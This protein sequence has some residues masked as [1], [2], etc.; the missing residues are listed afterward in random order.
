MSGEAS[1]DF[2][3]RSTVDLG[4]RGLDN[5][6]HHPDT[7]VLCLAYAFDGGDVHIWRS[8]VGPHGAVE[9]P[10]PVALLEH[11]ASG[12]MIRGWN[13]GFEWAIWN[14]IMARRYGWPPL[15]ITQCVD[16][17]AEAYAMGFPGSLGKAAA[18]LQLEEQKDDAGH[19]LMLRLSKPRAPRK[20]EIASLTYWEDDPAK[21]DRLYEYCKQDVRTEMAVAQ[22]LMRLAPEERKLWLLDHAINQTGTRIDLAAAHAAKAV[23][24]IEQ[25]RLDDEMR[26]VTGGAVG[27]CGS[28]QKLAQWL[29][30]QGVAAKGVAKDDVATLLDSADL[31]EH[32][33]AALRLRKEAAKS[34]TAKLDA[35]IASAS[36]DGRVRGV[37]QYHG[38]STG[39]WTGRT[40]QTQNIPRGEILKKGQVDDVLRLLVDLEGRPE[41]AADAL[42]VLYGPPLQVVSDCLRGLICATPGNR[43]IVA[44]YSAIEA[45]VLAWLAG[46]ESVL[47]V[48]RTHG[49]LYETTASSLFGVAL[50]GVT[51]EQRQIGKVCD[52][53]LGYGGSVGAFQSMARIYGLHLPDAR[54][55]EIVGTWRAG[56]AAI[57]AYWAALEHAATS[58]VAKGGKWRAGAAGCEV[59]FVHGAGHL[60]CKLPS[61]RVLCYP[62]ARIGAASWS[63]I[64]GADGETFSA[65]VSAVDADAMREGAARMAQNAGGRVV[66]YGSPR[67]AVVYR[68]VESQTKQWV[69]SGTYGGHLS[70]NITQAVA[71]DLLSEAMLRVEAAGYAI[72]MH[73]HDEIVAEVPDSFG[74]VEEFERIMAELPSWAQGLP[75]SAKGYAAQRFRK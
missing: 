24:A 43:L 1:V 20:N 4:P 6:A 50:D 22:R 18:A 7:D 46:E 36:L 19:R 16:T 64:E 58:A 2:E 51:P 56:H 53:A 52:L 42:R 69:W 12:V 45:R 67:N 37:H 35:M 15:P 73:V 54:V 17:M 74:S 5:Y 23:V 40:L 27:T 11:V 38:A 44:D 10:P 63:Q 33:A 72:T 13:V 8:G 32:A 29:R 59:E 61:G 31:P 55:K 66:D 21:F 28:T 75:V 41:L 49:K 60:W 62:F 34:S 14:A 3:T 57:V 68:T 65:S 71:R 39:R 9:D 70:E 30:Q 25:L 47:Q 26:E 48:F